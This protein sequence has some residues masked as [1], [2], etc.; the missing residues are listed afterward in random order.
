MEE[1]NIRRRF[2]I[3][4]RPFLCLTVAE[5]AGT[6]VTVSEET[7]EE[8]TLVLNPGLGF[9]SMYAVIRNVP[10][11]EMKNIPAIKRGEIVFEKRNEASRYA[12]ERG[13][14]FVL[15]GVKATRALTQDEISQAMEE[16]ISD[17]SIDNKLKEL[18]DFYRKV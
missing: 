6:G 4:T 14:P 8:L 11:N 9:Y 12:K 10:E 17:A 13:E 2:R 1:T 15:C 5:A 7:I 18:K 16:E 3:R